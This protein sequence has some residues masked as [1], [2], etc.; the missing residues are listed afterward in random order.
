MCGRYTFDDDED[1]A[2]VRVIQAYIRQRFGEARAAE[3]K[4]GEIFPTNEVPV[5]LTAEADP[6][7]GPPAAAAEADLVRKGS[8]DLIAVPMIWG[9][10]GFKGSQILINA[11]QETVAEKPTFSEGFARRRC[12]IPTTGFIE[13]SHD[14]AGKTVDKFRFNAGQDRMLYLAGIFNWFGDEMRFVILT[15]AAN[16]SMSAIHHRQP[17]ILA[18]DMI[19]PWIM[20]RD[21]AEALKQQPGPTMVHSLI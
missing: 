16:E 11:R 10:P 20:D 4:T 21:A 14:A 3:L 18:P 8:A 6:L 2:R 7:A 15:T 12:V 19:R 1:L 5:L 9:F 13:W 17:V